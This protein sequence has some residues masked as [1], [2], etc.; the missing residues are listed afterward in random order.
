[1]TFETMALV[2]CMVLRF[3][4]R[5]VEGG[6]RIPRQKQESLATN[7]FPPEEDVRVAVRRREG[8]ENVDWRFK[9]E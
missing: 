6:W 9:M 1:M 3:D 2:A 8:F 5:P 4:I 7:V